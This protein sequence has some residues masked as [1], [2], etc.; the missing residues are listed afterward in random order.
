ME[1]KNYTQ[2][3][4]K[5]DKRC[6]TSLS[7]QVNVLIGDRL[8]SLLA[9]ILDWADENGLE[10]RRYDKQGLALAKPGSLP[11]EAVL[12]S[13]E[14]YVGDYR[15]PETLITCTHITVRRNTPLGR[16]CIERFF[17][18]FE[19]DRAGGMGAF[20]FLPVEETR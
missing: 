19:K 1:T 12:F 17:T 3:G 9:R 15:K 16:E 10:L 13:E 7:P 5:H 11:R 20:V 18:G 4:R 6:D 8:P 14:R 2:F